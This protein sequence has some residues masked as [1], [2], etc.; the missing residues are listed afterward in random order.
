SVLGGQVCMFSAPDAV[1]LHL[2]HVAWAFSTGKGLEGY[3]EIGATESDSTPPS[4]SWRLRAMDWA[5]AVRVFKEKRT[6]KDGP[7]SRYRC[8]DVPWADVDALKA[9]E[10]ADAGQ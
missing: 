6:Q 7:Y 1:V 2:G 5:T 10:V 3:W 4:G 8:L 9:S